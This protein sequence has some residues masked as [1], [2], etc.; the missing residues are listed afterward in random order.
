MI[1][2][3]RIIISKFQ[4][5]CY[6]VNRP[7]SLKCLLIDPGHNFNRINTI[8]SEKNLTVSAILLTHCHIDHCNIVHMFSGVPIY[9]SKNEL[10]QIDYNN[11][12]SSLF[13]IKPNK[14]VPTNLLSDGDEFTIDDIL[15]K[16]IETPG[17][18]FGSTCYLIED[19]LFSGDTLFESN[20]GRTDLFGGDFM[21]LISSI[22]DKLL[23]LPKDIVVLPG[24]GE[25]TTIYNEQNLLDRF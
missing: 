5:N 22:K 23:V 15:I 1:E 12:Q 10:K 3:N 4:E 18:T 25:S 20:I 9:C 21:T 8:L 17:H 14:F 7:G 6:I 16:A 2:I 13:G 24:H 19:Y 11:S